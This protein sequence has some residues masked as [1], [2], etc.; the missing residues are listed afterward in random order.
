MPRDSIVPRSFFDFPSLHIPS[1]L[2]DMDGFLTASSAAAQGGLSVS[3]DDK[4]IYVEAAIPGVNP[5]DVEVTLDRGILW[6][7]GESRKEE[8]DKNKKFYRQAQRAFSYRVAVPG[9]ADPNVEPEAMC[10]DGII[11]LT[12]VKSPQ[13]QPKRIAIKGSQENGDQKQLKTKEGK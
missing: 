13:A 7:R 3:E 11:R 9:D 1:L 2:E 5:N 6:I 4:K 8:R 10:R 12:F